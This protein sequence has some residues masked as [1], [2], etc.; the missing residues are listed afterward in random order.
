MLTLC[1]RNNAHHKRTMTP[2]IDNLLES[3]GLMRH[4]VPKDNNSLFRCISHC[5]F[6][7]QSF[8]MV[9][10]QHLLQYSKLQTEEFSRISQMSVNQYEKMITD[11]KLDG[12]LFDMHIAAKMY[13]INIEC[14]VDTHPFIPII[15]ET[16]NS[17][18]KL[19]ICLN[20]EGTYDLVFIKE[21][22]ANLSLSQAI[23]Y[24]IIYNNVFKLSG[25][26]FAMKEMLYERKSIPCPIINDAVSLE[27]RATCTDMKELITSGI[28]PFPFKVAKALSPKLYRN[29]E[30][31]I[32]L[33]TKR[34][35]FYG[36][37]NNREFKEGSK[38]LVSI[39]NQDYHCYIQC[40]GGKN[41]LVEVY[42]KNLTQKM[43]VEFDKL[44]LI[45]VEEDVKERI[46][47][48]PLQVNRVSSTPNN[49]NGFICE[50]PNLLKNSG[51]I[52]GPEV[53][54]ILPDQVFPHL[55]YVQQFQQQPII[56]T[57]SPNFTNNNNIMHPWGI[58]TSTPPHVLPIP[59]TNFIDT[60]K[61]VGG[62]HIQSMQLIPWYCVS[63]PSTSSMCVQY[64]NDE[65]KSGMA[66]DSNHAYQP[67]LVPEFDVPFNQLY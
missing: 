47:E 6:L 32:W 45:S 17:L 24:E 52:H 10:R 41:D 11:S 35:K 12:K 27:K 1:A 58:S 40:I 61:A 62:P 3:I 42:V 34:D 16:P 7:T 60:S 67:G 13:K 59:P 44:K 65:E 38:C 5:V 14:Y 64:N 36:K 25:V 49:G 20:S 66:M 63:Q 37:W 33:N 18:K 9:V 55:R 22:V 4:I 26:H 57:N 51:S 15:I 30:Y 28:T 54:R 53:H 43:F 46:D 50:N 31:D 2:R 48:P 8:H 23:I 21:S 29:T 39:N 19:S 56:S